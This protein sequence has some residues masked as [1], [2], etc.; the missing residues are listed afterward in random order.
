MP[1]ERLEEQLQG[2]EAAVSN[3]REQESKRR[4]SCHGKSG[5]GLRGSDNRKMKE[6]R[7][8]E[9]IGCRDSCPEGSRP[10]AASPDNGRT[11]AGRS[12]EN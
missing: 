8:A 2:A 6:E 1:D 3:E 11:G 10:Q 7:I 12:P 9:A 4:K 5:K